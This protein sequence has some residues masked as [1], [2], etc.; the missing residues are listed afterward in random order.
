MG[1][2]VV[3]PST[4][5]ARTGSSGLHAFGFVHQPN[6]PFNAGVYRPHE[7][8]IFMAAAGARHPTSTGAR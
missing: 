1:A 8:A 4:F 5:K 2:S 3:E 7:C 6:W